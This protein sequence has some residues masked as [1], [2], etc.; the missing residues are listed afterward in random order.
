MPGAVVVVAF[1][2]ATRVRRAGR[3]R[4]ALQQVH[5]A[6]GGRAAHATCSSWRD[7][8]GVDVGQVYEMD[9]S[10]RTTAANAYVGGLGQHE[11]GG[12]LRHAAARLHARRD[13]PGR[14]P[15][16]R[17]RAPPRPAQRAALA[18]DRRALRHV[19]RRGAGRAA[20]ARATRR[21][22]RA[23]CRP[24][25]S[26]SRCSSPPLTWISNQLS[27]DVERRA[28]AFALELTRDP[29]TF[30]RLPAP[31]RAPERLRPGP[32]GALARVLFG[33][34]PTTLERIGQAEAFASTARAGGGGV[35][36][37]PL[38]PSWVCVARPVLLQRVDQLAH[39][40]GREVHPADDDAGHLALLRPR[41]RRGR[42]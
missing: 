30:D 11:A 19:G 26:R 4:P 13:A 38:I 24:W 32:A 22:A 15:R 31:D 7:E 5:A 8:A 2:A 16:A 1:G 17:A 10:R 33:T 6:A 18:R 28:D 36:G 21:S 12:A 9:A 27:R 35:S 41:G 34:H 20:R 29:R 14:R 3:A 37:R 23:R 25:R 39:E 42:R 40:A